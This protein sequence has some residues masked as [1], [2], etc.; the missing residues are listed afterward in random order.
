MQLI[1]FKGIAV[2]NTKNG[3]FRLLSQGRGLVLRNVFNTRY[4]WTLCTFIATIAVFILGPGIALA[5]SGDGPRSFPLLP[6]DINLL[7]V[8][9]M[10]QSGNQ[11]LDPGQTIPDAQ[12]DASIGILQYT[13][14]FSV[15]GHIG[16]A[17]AALPYADI[18]GEV[19]LDAPPGTV[20]AADT[21][22]GGLILGGVIGLVGSPAL[23]GKEFAAHDP[24]FQLGAVG[25]LLLPTGSYDPERVISVGSNRLAAQLVLPIT[26]SIGASMVDTT[27]TTFE[28]LPSITFFWDNTNPTGDATVTGQKPLYSL[29]AHVTRN[30]S[31]TTWVSFGG[32]YNSGG[33]TSTDDSWNNDTRESVGLGASVS[34]A[35]SSSVSV[36]VSYGEIVWRNDDGMD[37]KLFRIIGTYVF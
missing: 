32:I 15:N 2:Q 33:E 30:L 4:F 21:G 35:V 17:F 31:R 37:G 28:I 6:K 26:Y 34:F 29:E 8:Y 36:K 27:L 11:L 14:T 12:I 23:S 7:T 18:K 19:P 3:S 10:S 22:F 13:R 24:G 9:A 20:S 25:K 1:I 16:A 5:G